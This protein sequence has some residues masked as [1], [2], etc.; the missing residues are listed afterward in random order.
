MGVGVGTQ[1]LYM[2]FLKESI[3]ISRRGGG[4]GGDPVPKP[5][6]ERLGVLLAKDE[7]W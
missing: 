4:G 1:K 3:G 7:V 5:F 2:Y 6:N